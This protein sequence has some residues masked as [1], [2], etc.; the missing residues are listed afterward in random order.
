[1][2]TS[3]SDIVIFGMSE[4]YNCNKVSKSKDEKCIYDGQCRKQTL[5]YEASFPEL[6]KSYIGK[7]QRHVKTRIQEHISKVWKVICRDR[8]KC[9]NN[10]DWFGSKGYKRADA[11]VK[12]A[13]NLCRDC[14]TFKLWSWM[15]SHRISKPTLL[16]AVSASKSTVSL[17]KT[18]P[19][20]CCC[21]CSSLL[22]YSLKSVLSFSFD[23]LFST[24]QLSCCKWYSTRL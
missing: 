8:N 20:N 11:F 23:L 4:D 12:F 19:L 13:G 10:E 17:L 21:C 22:R 15:P 24:I 16:T 1:M 14:H 2:Y 7:T 9:G 18:R 3:V 6:E 5:V